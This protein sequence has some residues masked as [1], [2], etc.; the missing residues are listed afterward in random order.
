MT[1]AA[2]AAAAGY[3]RNAEAS[4]LTAVPETAYH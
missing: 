3:V 4:Y 2:A 1:V